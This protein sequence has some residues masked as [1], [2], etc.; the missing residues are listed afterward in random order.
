MHLALLLYL[1][2]LEKCNRSALCSYMHTNTQAKA[3][4]LYIR[5]VFSSCVNFVYCNGGR[6]KQRILPLPGRWEHLLMLL[7]LPEISVHILRKFGKIIPY[8][9]NIPWAKVDTGKFVIVT[10]NINNTK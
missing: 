10:V 8:N 4:N 6:S 2:N 3:R 5:K 7:F 1:E 9:Y